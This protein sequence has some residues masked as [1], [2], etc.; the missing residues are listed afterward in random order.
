M[1]SPTNVTGLSDAT[2]VSL[3]SYHACT[4]R[5][6]GAAHCWGNNLSGKLGDG[7]NTSSYSPVQ[8]SDLE[9]VVDVGTGSTFS[10]ALTSD[11]EVHCWGDNAHG[12]LGNG[13]TTTSWTPV[14]VLGIGI[15][16]G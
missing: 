2:S 4:R 1:L 7:T 13:G 9:A 15:G 12:Q 11:N 6:V 16:I 5:S 14:R 3:G 10:C 8:V